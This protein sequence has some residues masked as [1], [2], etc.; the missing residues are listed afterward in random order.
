MKENRFE[1]IAKLITEL[2]IILGELK[3]DF[4]ELEKLKWDWDKN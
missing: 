4:E 3:S 1:K 2:T